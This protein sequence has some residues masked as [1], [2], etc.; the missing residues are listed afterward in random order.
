[1]RTIKGRELLREMENA[2]ILNDTFIVIHS[3][4][5]PFY[6]E[7]YDNDEKLWLKNSAFFVSHFPLQK[8]GT[9]DTN[10]YTVSSLLSNFIT[11]K[12]LPKNQ[13]KYVSFGSFPN[14]RWETNF[15]C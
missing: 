6:L 3:D 4:H 9:I 12:E 1:M 13:K 8:K 15:G 7:P 14:F 2:N 10:H 11:N 5:G